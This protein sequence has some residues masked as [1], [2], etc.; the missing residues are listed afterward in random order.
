MWYVSSNGRVNLQ[1]TKKQAL[2]GSHSGNCD[3]DIA[4]LRQV[5]TISRQLADIDAEDLKA[6]LKEFGCWDDEELSDHE[7]NL[8]RILWIACGDIAEGL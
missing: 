5:Q 8:D 7:A 6:E 1:L 3:S 2:K 4:E